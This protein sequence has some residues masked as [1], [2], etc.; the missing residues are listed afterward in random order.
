MSKKT[1][2][3]KTV[4]KKERK[5]R[6]GKKGTKSQKPRIINLLIAWLID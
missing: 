4:G 6:E 1:P 3:R 5:N 2:E